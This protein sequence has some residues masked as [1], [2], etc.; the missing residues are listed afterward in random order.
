VN[1]T[2]SLF[3]GDSVQRYCDLYVCLTPLTTY[4]FVLLL[5]SPFDTTRTTTCYLFKHM[6]SQST[7]PTKDDQLCS[8]MSEL[9]QKVADGPYTPESWADDDNSSDFGVESLPSSCQPSRPQTPS[10]TSDKTPA[11]DPAAPGTAPT[12]DGGRSSSDWQLISKPKNLEQAPS[13]ARQESSSLSSGWTSIPSPVA[14]PKIKHIR[15]LFDLQNWSKA[16]KG[17]KV[18]TYCGHKVDTASPVSSEDL[19]SHVRHRFPDVQNIFVD[20]GESET[21]E[22]A[23]EAY[24]NKVVD[25][26]D[27]LV[28]QCAITFQARKKELDQRAGNPKGQA[29][30]IKAAVHGQ[31]ITAFHKKAHQLGVTHRAKPVGSACWLCGKTHH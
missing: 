9:A 25:A 29:A 28:A 1:T 23:Y 12:S 15:L 17:I 20:F 27:F 5:I 30:E 14:L 8:T 13:Q 16:S 2:F 6:K 10:N 4:N 21:T 11:D 31:I 3:S 22:M 26:L 18:R 19:A 7:I 24:T